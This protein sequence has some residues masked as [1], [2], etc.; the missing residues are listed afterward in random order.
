NQNGINRHKGIASM[1]EQ[2]DSTK[3]LF[4]TTLFSPID[5]LSGH[6]GP[7]KFKDEAISIEDYNGLIISPRITAQNFRHR[8]SEPGYFT[9]W[10]MAGDA[11]MIIIRSGTLSLGL[12]SG[13]QRHFSAGDLFIAKDCLQSNEEFNPNIHGHTAE[14][15]GEQSL[16]AV[17]IKL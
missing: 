3:E 14:V 8:V 2:L 12:R 11:T 15:V 6:T 5:E 13:E 4:I 1:T 16:M 9:D 17:H 7:S 10:H